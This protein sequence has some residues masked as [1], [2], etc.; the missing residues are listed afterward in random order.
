M[1]I[2]VLHKM[3]QQ[4]SPVIP[5]NRHVRLDL[6]SSIIDA[7]LFFYLNKAMSRF[8]TRLTASACKQSRWMPDQV[9]H[10]GFEALGLIYICVFAI[11]KTFDAL[12]DSSSQGATHTWL[13]A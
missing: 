4:A 13:P 12:N 1:L 11:H 2:D 7:L 6:A 8:C 9:R 10:D 3:Q 5:P